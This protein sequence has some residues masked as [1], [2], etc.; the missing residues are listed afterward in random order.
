MSCSVYLH[1]HISAAC[2]LQIKHNNATLLSGLIPWQ[3]VCFFVNSENKSML[4]I[5][6]CESEALWW[7]NYYQNHHTLVPFPRRWRWGAIKLWWRE[8][9]DPA[10][11]DIHTHIRARVTHAR[12]HALESQQA[13]VFLLWECEASPSHSLV[14]GG[15]GTEHLANQLQ[16]SSLGLKVSPPTGMIYSQVERENRSLSVSLLLRMGSWLRGV[17][18]GG[19]RE[20][21]LK[22]R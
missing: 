22:L 7:K 11:A 21:L 16:L 3:T 17:C 4:W 13:S 12:M 9:S 8:V 5:L 1:M 15:N 2:R 18:W 14:P 19:R 10:P 20:G 6:M